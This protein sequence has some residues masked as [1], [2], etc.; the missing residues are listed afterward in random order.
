VSIAEYLRKNAQI[1]DFA[2]VEQC[3]VE[4]CRQHVWLFE[5]RAQQLHGL[6]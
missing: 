2:A 3:L 4:K 5:F 6:L 1:A